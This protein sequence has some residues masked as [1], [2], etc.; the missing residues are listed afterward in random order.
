MIV[1]SILPKIAHQLC[2]RRW[3]RRR[4]ANI[5]RTRLVV[6]TAF[7]QQTVPVK[8]AEQSPHR[9]RAHIDAFG[10]GLPGAVPDFA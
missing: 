8:R 3:P 2:N 4:A 5:E 10:P 1:A 9:H 7:A 6:A